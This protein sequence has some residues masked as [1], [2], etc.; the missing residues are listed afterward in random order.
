MKLFE[1][2]RVDSKYWSAVLQDVF[3]KHGVR[4]PDGFIWWKELKKDTSDS[5]QQGESG[6]L[7]KSL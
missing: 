7:A 2:L 6:W 3:G 4:F 5:I 1:V